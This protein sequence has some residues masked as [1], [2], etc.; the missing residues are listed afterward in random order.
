[1][2]NVLKLASGVPLSKL[3]CPPNNC[4][5]SRAVINMNKNSRNNKEM[6]DLI[7]LSRDITRLRK[8]DQYFVTL[9][10]LRSRRALSTDKPKEPPLTLDHITSKIEPVMTTQSKRLKADSK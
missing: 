8:E 3:N 1:M 9:N 10:I 2:A 4:I 7:E 5:P 6:I